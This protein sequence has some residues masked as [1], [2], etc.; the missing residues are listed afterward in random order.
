MCCKGKQ[1][2]NCL[3]C[4]VGNDPHMQKIISRAN[5]APGKVYPRKDSVEGKPATYYIGSVLKARK[6][7][8]VFKAPVTTADVI[9]TFPK[10]TQVGVIQSYI[11]RDGQVWWDVN[12]HSG[13]HMGWVL[14]DPSLFDS[15]IIEQTAS[16]KAH[17]EKVKQIE[18]ILTEK[19]A[20]EK[21][22]DGV[23]NAA[24]GLGDTLGFIGKNLTWIIAAIVVLVILYFVLQF[25]KVNG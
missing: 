3:D 14:H 11:V 20:I 15:K 24:G 1:S 22:A 12:W 6:P 7:V 2:G 21:L 25:K 16:G 4:P 18:K 10:G 9:K 8:T 5:I 23:S 19:S 17:E 13:K